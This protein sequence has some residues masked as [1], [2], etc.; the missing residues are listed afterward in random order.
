MIR[1]LLAESST[2]N[3]ERKRPRLQGKK[4]RQKEKKE[5]SARPYTPGDFCMVLTYLKDLAFSEVG[6]HTLLNSTDPCASRYR[7]LR[8]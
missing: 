7:Y 8:L 3:C 6:S 1:T 2:G 5:R 4:Q